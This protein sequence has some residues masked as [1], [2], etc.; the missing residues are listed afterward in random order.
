MGQKELSVL[1]EKLTGRVTALEKK[2]TPNAALKGKWDK[3]FLVALAALLVA[4][5]GLP[6]MLFS[7]IEPHLQND[8]KNDVKIE[9]ADQLKEPLKKIGEISE[10]VKEIK[11]KLEVLDP[12]IRELTVKR[13]SE[14]SN[15]NPKELVSRLPE[16]K[17]LAT[18][19]K[20]ESVTVKPETVEKVGQKLIAVGT[21]DAWNTALKF[22]NY[23]SFL[24]VSLSIA[25]SN[26]LPEGKSLTTTYMRNT[27]IGMSPPQFSIAGIV[28]KEQS[29]QFVDMRTTDPN[30]SLPLGNEWIIATG[31]ALIIDNMQLKKMIFQNVYIEYDGGPIKMQEVYFLNCTFVVKQQR[32]GEQ[33]VTAALKP[34]P[35]VNFDAS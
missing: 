14:V 11:G 35:A 5:I 1:L 9:V 6:I 31:G 10:D 34:S 3:G 8:L 32:N 15:L 18:I 26:V 17:R 12:F 27:P 20:T 19:A 7:W 33:L 2:R 24:N 23:K 13:L 29:A 30:A 21:T 22:L 4:A 16:L 28:P 25:V